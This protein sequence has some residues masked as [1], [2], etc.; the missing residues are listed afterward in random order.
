MPFIFGKIFKPYIPFR[1]NQS[2]KIYNKDGLKFRYEEK[3]F[4]FEVEDR[5]QSK[6]LSVVFDY[7]DHEEVDDLSSIADCK[8]LEL[9]ES[10]LEVTLH[11]EMER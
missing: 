3:I 4:Y 7:I 11:Y 6:A 10:M 2:F 5:F 1:I 9:L 8:D